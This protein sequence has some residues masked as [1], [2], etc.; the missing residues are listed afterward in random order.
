M[1]KNEKSIWKN[2]AV[3]NLQELNQATMLNIYFLLLQTDIIM[4]ILDC[5]YISVMNK[6]D[7]FYQW[8]IAV[9]NHEKFIIVNHHDLKIINVVFMN[10]QKFSLYAQ[11][12]MN[13]IFYSYK[14]FVCCYIDD[15]VIFSKI[16]K[17]HLQYLNMIFSLFNKFEIIFK[18]VK[19]HLNYLSIILLNQWV[20]DFDMIILQK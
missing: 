19:T 6:T 8:W 17:N 15:I 16:L 4:L 12:M 18:K 10:Y 14:F 1:Y 2:Q 3:I 7:F 13:M 5:K 9:K 20:D 11:Y